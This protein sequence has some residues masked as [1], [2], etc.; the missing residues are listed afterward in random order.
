MDSNGSEASVPVANNSIF[1]KYRLVV[2]KIFLKT[3]R[4]V[5]A[6]FPLPMGLQTEAF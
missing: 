2:Y 6:N 5:Q 4:G 1:K 3:K